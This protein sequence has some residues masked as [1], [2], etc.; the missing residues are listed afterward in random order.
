MTNSARPKVA[1]FLDFENLVLSAQRESPALGP[2]AVPA[3]ALRALCEQHGSARIRRAYA[4][5]G[6]APFSLHQEDLALNGVDLVQ[7]KRFGCCQK[8]AADVRMAV[9][10]METLITHPDVNTFVLVSGDGDYSPLAQRL[11]E[12]GKTVVGVGARASASPRLIAVCSAYQYWESLVADPAPVPLQRRPRPGVPRLSTAVDLLLRALDGT[13]VR[14]ADGWAQAGRVKNLMLDMQPSFDQT[15]FGVRTFTAFLALPET[16]DVIELKRQ[17]D[18][19]PLI[20]R[21]TRR[22]SGPS[23]TGEGTLVVA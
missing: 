23:D 21:R 20:R 1:L 15:K 17:H 11:R 7:V 19:Q 10:A 14:T 8:N 2:G 4:D 13:S 16:E 5:W 9:D 18:G 6:L 12:Y 3:T 22:R